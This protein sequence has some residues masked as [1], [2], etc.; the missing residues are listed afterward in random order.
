M[1]VFGGSG[2][3]PRHPHRAQAAD[4][5]RHLPERR[6]RDV[7]VRAADEPDRL[8]ARAAR[9]A[10]PSTSS[11]P[12]ASRQCRRAR[13]T[14]PRRTCTRPVSPTAIAGSREARHALPGQGYEVEVPLPY[15]IDPAQALSPRSQ[16][17]VASAYRRHLRRS[18][19]DDRPV[20]I[21]N[22]KVE[23]HGPMPGER[24][25]YRLQ[26]SAARDRRRCKG[27]APGLF[28]RGRRLCA[29]PGLRPLRARA[30]RRRSTGRR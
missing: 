2:P 5:A 23:A 7:G 9:C 30:G 11:R 22:W 21:V 27:H 15:G 8:R 12:S 19:F 13:A 24:H 10:R 29:M 1:V 25:P 4:P 3:H 18:S 6:G 14:R 17:F 20:E 28:S 16:A 26:E